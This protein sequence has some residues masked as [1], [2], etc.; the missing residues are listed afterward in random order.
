MST[1]KNN[2]RGNPPFQFRLDPE[3]RA[4]M[5]IAQLQDGDESLAAWIKRIIRKELQSRDIKS[6]S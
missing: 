1:H 4:L 3:L 2:R 5:E 6:D